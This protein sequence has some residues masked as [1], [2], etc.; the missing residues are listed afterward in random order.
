KYFATF[1]SMDPNTYGPWGND[2]DEPPTYWHEEIARCAPKQANAYHLGA[3]V[4]ELTDSAKG[5]CGYFCG[6]DTVK[7]HFYK[8]GYYNVEPLMANISK[9]Y[10]R[11]LPRFPVP[12]RFGGDP[13][14]LPRR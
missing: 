11:Y 7:L 9:T 5:L 2:A 6:F 3:K 13:R 12:K 10:A 14:T 1:V 4:G 8:I